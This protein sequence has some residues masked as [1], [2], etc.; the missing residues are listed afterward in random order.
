MNNEMLKTASEVLKIS[1]DEAQK[2]N[3]F[4][5]DDDAYLFWKPVRGGGKLVIKTNGEKLTVG[6][7]IDTE[8]MLAMFRDGKRN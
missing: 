6:S 1:I 7:L 8:T 2:H 5:I 3:K 4:L